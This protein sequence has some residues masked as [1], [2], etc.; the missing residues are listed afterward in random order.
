MFFNSVYINSYLNL[1]F[2]AG[3]YSLGNV[4][5][6]WVNILLRPTAA[7]SWTCS[8]FSG[9][10]QVV[11]TGHRRRWEGHKDTQKDLCAI[12]TH[13]GW[14]FIFFKNNEENVPRKCAIKCT[15]AG[16]VNI[17]RGDLHI[18]TAQFCWDQCVLV[19]GGKGREYKENTSKFSW[20]HNK[21]CLLCYLFIT[22]RV[23]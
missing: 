5:A 2:S 4:K 1:S 18:R 23:F 15:H 22:D 10:R 19:W 16:S 6:T 21:Q 17:V 9:G 12:S 3:G 13:W 20:K 8:H 14:H 11:A 7:A